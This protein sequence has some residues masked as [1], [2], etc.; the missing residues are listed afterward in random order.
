VHL[1]VVR[2]HRVSTENQNLARQATTTEAYVAETFPDADVKTLADADTGTDID[3]DGNERPMDAIQDAKV[4]AVVV[5]D[6]SR[7][8]RSVR[9]LI[10]MVDRLREAGMELH[11]IDDPL[12]VRPID[13]DPTQGLMLQ[14]LAAVAEFEAK[15]TQQRVREGIAARQ[16][17][18]DYH[19]GPAPLG[20]NKSDGALIQAPEYDRV[21]A[22]LD[23][24]DAGELSK[25]KAAKRLDTSRPTINRSL[26]R[27]EL[28]GLN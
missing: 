8:A 23:M 11:C 27:A 28:Y 18:E 19:H 7:I 26:Y 5:K 22:V 13:A 14:I 1:T 3:R 4:D 16:D 12:E 9:D 6:M 17:S 15:I 24:V 2:Y 21:C 20:F 10:H 25:R